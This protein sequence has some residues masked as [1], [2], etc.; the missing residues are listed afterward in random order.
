MALFVYCKNIGGRKFNTYYHH[1]ENAKNQLETD[2]A[3]MLQSGG[4]ITSHRD[5]MNVAKGWYDYDYTIITHRGETG[6][7][8]I[9]QAFYRDDP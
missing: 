4:K 7:L 5:G 8:S 1:W 6:E 3:E 9:I 2:L